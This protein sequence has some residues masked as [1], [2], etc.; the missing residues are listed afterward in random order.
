MEIQGD[1]YQVVYNPTTSTVNIKGVLR[2]RGITEYNQI[3]Q[4]LN[5]VAAEKSDTITV[6][7]RELEF[8]NSSGINILFKFVVRVRELASSN[9][10]VRGSSQIPWQQKSLNNLPRLMADVKLEWE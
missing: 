8:L 5:D 1:E 4:T 3:V 2:L 7:L 10:V 6:D 9:L